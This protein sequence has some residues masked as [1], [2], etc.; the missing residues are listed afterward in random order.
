MIIDHFTYDRPHLSVEY[1]YVGI[2][3]GLTQRD[4]VLFGITEQLKAI[5]KGGRVPAVVAAVSSDTGLL[6]ALKYFHQEALAGKRFML[7]FVSHG[8]QQG[9]AAGQDFVT[10][11]TLRPFLQ[12]IHSATQESLLLN[13]STCKGLHG[14]KIV[15]ISGPPYPF[16]GLIGATQDLSVSDA[17]E[18]NRRMYEKWMT[19]MPVQKLVPETNNELGR[20]V[21]LNMSAEGYHKL[22]VGNVV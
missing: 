16:F 4:R 2:I 6:E 9:I 12:Q 19:G 8:N 10:W 7:H 1:D 21:L 5:L 17:L 13:M 18:A 3:D 11:A 20:E 15:E 22:S 14:M